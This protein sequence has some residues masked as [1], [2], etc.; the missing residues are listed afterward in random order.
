MTSSTAVRTRRLDASALVK[1]YIHEKGSDE[2][3][4]YR[5]GQ[6]NWYTTPALLLFGRFGR[7]GRYI[8]VADPLG[9]SIGC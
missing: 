8:N 9:E 7:S 4:T 2:L 3:R 5:Q 1:D 6:A